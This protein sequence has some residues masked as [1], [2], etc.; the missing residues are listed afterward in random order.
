MKTFKKTFGMRVARDRLSKLI[1]LSHKGHEVTITRRGVEV[2][3][4]IPIEERPLW[5]KE[6]I[7]NAIEEMKKFRVKY[8]HRLRGLTI[9][10]SIREGRR[11]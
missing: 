8:R 1:E 4:I 3:R 10:Q 6:S 7:Q 9:K 11:F 2:A 5:T